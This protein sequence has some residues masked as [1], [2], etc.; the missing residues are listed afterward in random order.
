L[1]E[2]KEQV[3]SFLHERRRDGVFDSFLDGLKEKATIEK[4]T[5][6]A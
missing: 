6:D 4:V 2:V 3:L 1:D 5:E